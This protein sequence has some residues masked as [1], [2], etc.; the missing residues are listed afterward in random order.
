MQFYPLGARPTPT[1]L[2]PLAGSA[3]VGLDGQE[4]VLVGSTS[5]EAPQGAKLSRPLQ[6]IG[7]KHYPSR[8]LS[9]PGIIPT[10]LLERRGSDGTVRSSGSTPVMVPGG[11]VTKPD[12]CEYRLAFRYDPFPQVG[13]ASRPLGVGS[14]VPPA[15]AGTVPSAPRGLELVG[16]PRS[17][18]ASIDSP[19]ASRPSSCP[20]RFLGS[21]GNAGP[22]GRANSPLQLHD[23]DLPPPAQISRC[24]T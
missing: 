15:H 24:Q 3:P 16:R 12:L 11:C 20:S 8:P 1:A 14:A 2:G 13:V 7:P 22:L 10:H 19:F 5:V 4:V 6:T 18:L 21:A 9:Q 17:S 23:S